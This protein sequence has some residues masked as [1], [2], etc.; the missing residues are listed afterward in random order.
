MHYGYCGTCDEYIVRPAGFPLQWSLV[1][2]EYVAH[3]EDY[4]RT[5]G[6]PM[7]GEITYTFTDFYAGRKIVIY[8]REGKDSHGRLTLVWA[9][10]DGV[11]DGGLRYVQIGHEGKAM[12]GA[13]KAVKARIDVDAANEELRPI[14]ASMCRVAMPHTLSCLQRAASPVVGSVVWVRAAGAIRQGKVTKV[15]PKRTE[16]AYVTPTSPGTVRRKS[17]PSDD[18]MELV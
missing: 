10:T 15:G 4:S 1:T 3:D 12:E 16:V 9:E 6:V 2:D 8:G 14:L 7:V 13:L 17:V 18:V 5:H 11:Q